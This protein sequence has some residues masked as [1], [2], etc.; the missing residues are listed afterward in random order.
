M[1]LL[2]IELGVLHKYQPAVSQQQI[3]GKDEQIAVLMKQSEEFKSE[4][5][6]LRE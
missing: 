3:S 2:K 6:S 1:S 5:R 4:T